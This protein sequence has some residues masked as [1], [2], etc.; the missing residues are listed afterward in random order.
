MNGKTLNKFNINKQLNCKVNKRLTKCAVNIQRPTCHPQ[1]FFDELCC[2]KM[3]LTCKARYS[4]E[5]AC[6]LETIDHDHLML[7]HY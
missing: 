5:K 2:N 6:L 3:T 1:S 7:I 4:E